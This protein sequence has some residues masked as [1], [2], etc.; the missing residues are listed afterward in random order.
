MREIEERFNSEL[1]VVGVHSGKFIAERETSR[2]ADAAQRLGV[3]HA[4]VNDRQ[5]R[6]W[7]SYA[8]RAWPTIVVIDPTG[9]VVGMRAGEFTADMIAPSLEKI[10]K[11]A[12]SGLVR[13]ANTPGQSVS[14]AP[15]PNELRYP[16]KVAV[17]GG[18]MA[19]A[20]SANNR[21]LVA[22]LTRTAQATVR[23]VYGRDRGYRD[24]TDARFDHPQGVLFDGD[25][26]LVADA[27]NHAIRE[28]D[29]ATGGTRTIAGTGKQL[30]TRAD[31]TA[32]ALSSPWDLVRA[33]DGIA[34]A[35]A[36]NHKLYM[37]DRTTQT[38]RVFAG[39][40][41]EEIHDGPRD[42][43]ALAQPMGICAD[44]RRVYFADS[45]SSAIRYADLEPN[46]IVGTLAG[47]GLFDFGDADGEGTAIRL[48]HSQGVLR[49]PDGRLL[50]VDSYNDALKWL[51]PGS[52]RVTTWVR[53]LSEPGGAAFG[54]G[55]VYVADTNA[56][57]IAVIGLDNGHVITLSLDWGSIGG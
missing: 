48:Q 47:S 37:L 10:I 24:G 36:G 18:R 45:E 51:D 26:L 49:A 46:G 53:G 55:H 52:R 14:R 2:I 13:V 40:G 42:T 21:V 50:V 20:D 30:R 33:G 56:H 12:G 3:A 34:I 32:G 16:G 8:V 27:F 11:Q 22:D 17:A 25:A 54:E 31:L 29:L 1:T 6:I 4:V 39:S 44:E 15:A 38:A 5:F 23:A 28:I 57:R 43:A 35:M 41:A 19:I 7:R 9:Y